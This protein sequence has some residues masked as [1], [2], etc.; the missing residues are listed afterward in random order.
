MIFGIVTAVFIVLSVTTG[1]LARRHGKTVR[2]LHLIF[3]ILA[4]LSCAI[5][6]IITLPLFESRP[7][8]V[9]VTGFL[10]LA[11]LLLLALSGV[12]KWKK[13]LRFHRVFAVSAILIM[14]LH[15]TFNISAL[16]DYRTAAA[17]IEVDEVDLSQI[18]DG[19]YIGEYDIGY[20]YA[21][22]RVSIASGKISN[23]EIF[24]HRTERGQA[25]ERIIT[26]ME[27]QQKIKVDA[28]SGATN[29]SNV[30]KKAVYNALQGGF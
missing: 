18:Q 24:E 27:T 11:I 22:V 6:L 21:K 14:M 10:G 15:V 30:I 9:W 28:V 2:S 5:H 13:F 23:I 12:F 8:T 29:S 19:D 25:A 17:S 7:W 3:G 26:D 20:V 4:V 16:N 1:I